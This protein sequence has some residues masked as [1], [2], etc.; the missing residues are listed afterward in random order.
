MDLARFSIRHARAIVFLTG[1]LTVLGFWAY[2]HTPASIFPDMR[3]SRVDV[4][5]DAGN[6][7]P[8]QVRVAVTVPVE[9]AFLGLR[10]VRRVVSKSGQGSAEWVV[11]FDPRSDA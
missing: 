9:Q 3:F 2:L 8:E 5:A 1:A 11:E 6:L 10:S 7:P 4:V